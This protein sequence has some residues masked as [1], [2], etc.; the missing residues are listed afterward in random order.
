MGGQASGALRMT[1]H[2]L[3]KDNVIRINPVVPSGRYILD[4]VKELEALCGLGYDK[5]QHLRLD[6]DVL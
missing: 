2:L 4:S 1:R 3:G 5:V 6:A